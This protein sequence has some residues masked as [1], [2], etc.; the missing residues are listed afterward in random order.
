[1]DI[2]MNISNC[3]VIF[4]PYCWQTLT[5]YGG[6]LIALFPICG[7]VELCEC[8]MALLIRSIY[9]KCTNPKKITLCGLFCS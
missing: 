7:S 8:S 9:L 4:S 5:I 1:M 2:H 3:V 6:T